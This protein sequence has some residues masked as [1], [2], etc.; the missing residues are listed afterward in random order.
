LHAL[1]QGLAWLATLGYGLPSSVGPAARE[2][3]ND[4]E[5]AAVLGLVGAGGL[6]RL[7]LV[8][9][10]VFKDA[11]GIDGDDRDRERRGRVERVAAPLPAWL[12]I[13]GAAARGSQRTRI[14]SIAA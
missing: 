5:V 6:G 10:S 2:L 11:G 9:L 8:S 3:Q 4:L 13:R 7:L 1:F 12:V 14:V